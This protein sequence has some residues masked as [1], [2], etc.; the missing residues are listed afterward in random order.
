MTDE[1]D[2]LLI[3]SAARCFDVDDAEWHR[4]LAWFL[5]ACPDTPAALHEQDGGRTD[6]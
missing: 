4:L 5:Q 2:E 6:A 1:R 3:T